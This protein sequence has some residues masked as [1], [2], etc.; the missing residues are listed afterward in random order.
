MMA[1]GLWGGF[2]EILPALPSW[3]PDDCPSCKHHILTLL[4][5]RKKVRGQALFLPVSL[6]SEKKILPRYST[7]FLLH[8]NVQRESHVHHLLAM[9]A[10]N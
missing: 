10:E 9:K 5:D 4:K 2:C 7:G 3:L 1:L 8:P 6:L